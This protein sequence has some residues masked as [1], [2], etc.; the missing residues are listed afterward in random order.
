MGLVECLQ[1]LFARPMRR[2][3]DAI[4]DETGFDGPSRELVVADH[5]GNLATVQRLLKEGAD[6]NRIGMDG[7]TPLIH[8]LVGANID[9]VKATLRA[10]AAVNAVSPCGTA[11]TQAVVGGNP[12]AIVLLLKAGADV[13]LASWKTAPLIRAVS[14]YPCSLEVVR[15]LVQ[16]GAGVNAHDNEGRTVLQLAKRRRSRRVI[17][18]LI[19]AGAR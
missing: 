17:Q 6:P 10:G 4:G 7:H 8:A 5:S 1:F 9:I 2:D 12:E 16:A 18:L 14:G 19:D 13:N 15:L 11:L 3:S